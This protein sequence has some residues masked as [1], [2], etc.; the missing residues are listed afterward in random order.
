MHLLIPYAA[1]HAE[2]CQAALAT[3]KLPNL[4]KLLSRLSAQ[5]PDVGDELSWSPPHERAMARALGLTV[6]DGQIPWAALQAG[7]HPELARLGGAWAFVTLCRWQASMHEVT[8]RQLPMRELSAAESDGLF[9]TMQPFFA[10]DGITLYA[11]EPGRWLAHGAVFDGLPSASP[12]R[13]LGRNLTH[14]MPTAAQAGSLI[15][16]MSEVQMLL[17]THPLNDARAQRGALPVNAIWLSGTGTLPAMADPVRHP[18]PPSVVATLRETALQE[19]WATWA[20]AWQTLD[21][22]QVRQLL[23]AQTRGE[24]VQL[25]LCGER[26]A[27]TWLTQP[28]ALMQ[29]I[30]HLFGSAPP[31]SKLE[32]L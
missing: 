18:L 23:D 30:K 24:A 15:R 21:A 25:T 29:K 5:T 28:Q 31:Q 17:Y 16:L 22:T 3:L 10:E 4:Q 1:S 9:A 7:K 14:W 12:D 27:Q 8:L 11:G 26:H 2:G 20:S 19:D 32:Q 13:V 6:T